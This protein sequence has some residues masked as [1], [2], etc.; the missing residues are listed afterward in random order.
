MENV[1][2]EAARR[3]LRFT[4]PNGLLTVEDLFD[5]PLESAANRANLD[6]L[7]VGLDRQIKASEGSQSFVRKRAKADDEAQIKL[8]IVKFV[9]DAKLAA[10]DA[11][12]K[13]AANREL[14]QN[15]LA[16]VSRKQ[17]AALE[18][19]PVEDL[20]KKIGELSED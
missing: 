11:A 3:K 14:K 18:E 16:I 2:A 10:R 7:A 4:A 5:L 15:L 6:D 9:I 20:L 12:E 8:E 19:M 1:F 17:N 13:R